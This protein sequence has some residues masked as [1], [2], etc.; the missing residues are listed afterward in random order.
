MKE[1]VIIALVVGAFVA[2]FL[3]LCPK[4]KLMTFFGSLARKVARK[5]S[6]A[7]NSVL[8]KK[9]M[10]KLEEGILPTLQATIFHSVMEFCK[11]IVSDN[12]SRKIIP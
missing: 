8:G 6:Q 2:A 10:E 4:A 12:E 9:A 11:E 1:S 5:I 3:R 7:G